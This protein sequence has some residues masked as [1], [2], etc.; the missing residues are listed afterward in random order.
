[1]RVR[2][3][4]GGQDPAG[5]VLEGRGGGLGHELKSDAGRILGGRAL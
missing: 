2:D 4:R 5:G 1:M 3:Q